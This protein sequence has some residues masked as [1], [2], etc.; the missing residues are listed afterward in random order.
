MP[1]IGEVVW[2]FPSNTGIAV[3]V[4]T[5]EGQDSNHPGRG[6]IHG[7]VVANYNKNNEWEGLT[8]CTISNDRIQKVESFEAFSQY[9]SL[10]RA[11]ADTKY[12][13]EG[14]ET[15]LEAVKAIPDVPE[16]SIPEEISNQ[17]NVDFVRNTRYGQTF[18]VNKDGKYCLLNIEGGNVSQM[19][20]QTLFWSCLS[21]EALACL[22]TRWRGE[23]KACTTPK[24]LS[25]W[26]FNPKFSFAPADYAP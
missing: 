18:L 7:Q 11:F 25:D 10:L 4:E 8:E 24:S 23:N 6:S 9:K 3:R 22:A 17:V 20:L 16:I 15:T 2:A 13:R 12:G 26:K 21:N 14:F 1:K 5:M 19:V